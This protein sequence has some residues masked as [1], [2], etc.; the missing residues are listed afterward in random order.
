M[1]VNHLAKKPQTNGS[2]SLGPTN[3]LPFLMEK[4]N[5]LM[6]NQPIFPPT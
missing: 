5:L 2:D 1:Q 6:E 4:P 3:T